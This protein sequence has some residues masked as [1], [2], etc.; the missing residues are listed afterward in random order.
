MVP[1]GPGGPLG[2]LA[3]DAWTAAMLGLWNAGLWLLTLVMRLEDRLLTP[4]LRETGPAADVYRTTFWLAAGL[5]V[6]MLLVQLTLTLLRRDGGGLGVALWGCGKFVV[7]WAGWVTWGVAVVSAC[8]GL[9]REILH[10][11]LRVRRW[12]DWKIKIL[13]DPGQVVDATVATVLGLLGLVLWLA[14]LGHILIMIT[15]AATL[16]VLAA[17]TPIAAAGLVGDT[18]RAWFWKS[19]R[20]FHAAALTPVLMALMIGVGAQTTT[21]VADGL[22]EGAGK[23]VGTALPGVL[24]IFMSCFAPLGLF[25]LLAFVDPATPAGHSIRQAIDSVVQGR[26][27]LNGPQPGSDAEP[28]DWPEAAPD[29]ADARQSSAQDDLSASSTIQGEAPPGGEGRSDGAPSSDPAGSAAGPAPTPD[30]AGSNSVGSDAPAASPPAPVAGDPASAGPGAPGFP[31]PWTPSDSSH[32]GAGGA[33]DT[34]GGG[35]SGSGVTAA[36]EAATAV[37]I[38]PV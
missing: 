32:S 8:S 6:V 15:R 5:V 34:G 16:I 24:I 9:T 7:V 14:A 33:S 31:T 18:G 26:M 20:W 36:G 1:V 19:V 38:V 3:T 13:L 25:R 11:L 27:L 12:G 30:A 2:G 37:P 10:S 29:G 22:A 17:V 4:D 28:G 23:A 21:G 35:P